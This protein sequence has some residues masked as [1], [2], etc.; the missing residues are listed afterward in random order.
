MDVSHTKGKRMKVVIILH[1]IDRAS[2]FEDLI[3]YH[4]G[5]VEYGFILLQ[6]KK[7]HISEYLEQ[8]NITYTEIYYKKK[9]DILG[10]FVKIIRF[11]RFFKPEVV[12]THLFIPGLLGLL[13]SLLLRIKKRIYTRHHSDFHHVYHP[14]AVK[15]DRIISSMATKIIAISPVVR[16]ILVQ[17][18]GVSEKKVELI[19]HGFHLEKFKHNNQAHTS[20]LRQK[21]NVLSLSPV[22]GVVSRYTEWKGIQYIIPAF[23]K[24]L[25]DYPN[26]LLI[27]ANAMGEY[28]QEIK[29][30]LKEIPPKNYIEIPFEPDNIELFR[31]F[32]AFI[33]VPI[34]PSSEAFGQVYVEALA[35]GIPSVFTRS[36]IANEMIIDGENALVVPYQ[37]S[38]AIYQAT[39][40][41][42]TDP[43]LRDRLII[44]GKA[45]V[46]SFSFDTFADRT[47]QLYKE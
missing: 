35:I 11:I 41:I 5:T 24:L 38:E 18:E 6:E 27:L 21:Y 47:L 30:I 12:H 7:G 40:R 13:A 36:G 22:I 4:E 17:K 10:T 37:N 39:K 46:R 34:N 19:P 42:L 25:K 16:D 1:N 23:Q 29:K 14:H 44:N 15:Y 33:H 9:S 31:M 28:Q 2:Q 32:D 8:H 43:V 45:S 3:R 20:I 26:A